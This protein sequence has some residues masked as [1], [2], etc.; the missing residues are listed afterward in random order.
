MASPARTLQLRKAFVA[1]GIPE[2]RADEALALFPSAKANQPDVDRLLT[3]V[4]YPAGYGTVKELDDPKP[5]PHE[6][7]K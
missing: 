7:E 3:S 4:G 1:V 6:E 2:E 5:N